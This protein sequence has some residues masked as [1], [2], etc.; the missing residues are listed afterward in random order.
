MDA[1][2]KLIAADRL[3]YSVAKLVVRGVLDT[4]SGPADELLVYLNVGGVNGPASVPEW[5]VM[6]ETLQESKR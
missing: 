3:A 5:I 2:M 1:K 4:R 6:Y